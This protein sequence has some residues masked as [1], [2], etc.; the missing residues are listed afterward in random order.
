MST[1]RTPGTTPTPSNS[2][3][4][5]LDAN[6]LRPPQDKL[7]YE[8]LS[9]LGDRGHNSMWLL[10]R[11]GRRFFVK[12]LRD[13]TEN[14][15]G[16]RRLMLRKEYQLTMRL[17]HP[18]IVRTLMLDDIEGVGEAIV[19]EWIEGP[20]L[21]AWL[22]TEP[23]TPS[24][25]SVAHDIIDAL[26]YAAAVGV[27]HRDLKPDNIMIR[28]ASGH[29]CI[30]DFGLGDS[31]DYETLKLSRGTASYGAPEQQSAGSAAG[32]PADVY[33]LGRILEVMR[34]PRR[35]RRLIRRCVSED[36]ARRPDITQVAAG[37]D[38]ATR[39]HIQSPLIITAS[40]A[41]IAAASA[42][43]TVTL[44][45][46]TSPAPQ[47]Q[48]ML[49]TTAVN[50]VPNEATVS[51]ENASESAGTDTGQVNSGAE[52]D[53]GATAIPPATASGAAQSALPQSA[54]PDDLYNRYE[55]RLDSVFRVYA[56]LD[57]YGSTPPYSEHDRIMARTDA[58][59]AVIADARAEM[60][61][62]HYT[63]RHIDTVIMTL[64]AHWYTHI[65]TTPAR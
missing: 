57:R 25:V 37:F 55:S 26:S 11:D 43:I 42:I 38:A 36:P 60:A 46:S 30:I 13:G 62:L 53:V 6:T 18:G 16:C 48:E 35:Y 59:N 49:D 24:R 27:A 20:T 63:P 8:S 50:I 58:L 40:V 14:A 44:R 41:V 32:L 22:D 51:R 2:A 34:L 4:L 1:P 45:T 7:R 39:R 33:A 52:A 64:Q 12:G 21:G 31:D 61:A 47:M 65:S 23:D 29:P 3:M 54:V 28:R 15:T 56:D 17:D 5:P 9:H 19:M 10:T